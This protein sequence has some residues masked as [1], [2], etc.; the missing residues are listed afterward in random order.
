MEKRKKIFNVLSLIFNLAIVIST[1]YAVVT[2]YIG[3][4]MGNMKV[5]G[6]ECFVFFTV[7]SNIL[8]AVIS[9]IMLV[10]NFKRI[11][12]IKSA[13]PQWMHILKFIGT[14]AVTLTFLTVVA[15]LGPTMGYDIMFEG[16]CLYMH[17]TTPLLAIIAFC[18]FEAQGKLSAKQALFGVIPTIVYGAVYFTMVILVGAENGGW[19]DFYGFNS[20][21]L[22]GRWYISIIAMPVATYLICLALKAFHNAVGK[23]N[24][25]E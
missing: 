2:F 17:L 23:S 9:A 24:N 25:A 4:G 15:F 6:S 5:Q 18:I 3:T 13:V 14:T 22:E 1:I 12:D 20:G 21:I 7:D 8:M 10:F 16:S 11:K 19:K